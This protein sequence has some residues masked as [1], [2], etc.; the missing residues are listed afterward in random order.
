RRWSCRS[1]NVSA[2]SC[3]SSNI[4]FSVDYTLV[5]DCGA[6]T[7]SQATS[8]TGNVIGQTRGSRMGR[9]ATSRSK[10]GHRRSTWAI[11]Q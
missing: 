10:R 9:A 11:P 6:S 8:G 1:K 4:G 5:A 7:P 2:S 3:F